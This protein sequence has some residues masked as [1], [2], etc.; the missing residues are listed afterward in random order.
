MRKFIYLF[1]IS[2]ILSSIV[3]A[4]IFTCKDANGNTIYADTPQSCAGNKAEEVKVDSLPT[5]I[6]T[7]SSPTN[8]SSSV[9]AKPE[10]KEKYNSL[11][12][13][14]PNA[15]ETLRSNNGD[16][17]ISYQTDPVLKADVGHRYVVIVNGKEVYR[18]KNSS[19]NLQEADRGEYNV[20]A[21][22]VTANGRT[23]IESQD[24]EFFL[25]RFS[26]LQNGGNNGGGGGRQ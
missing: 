15:G 21:K 17:T 26:A 4:E 16:V 7:K 5:L 11:N 19:V 6:Q 18:G 23:L 25:Q 12:I 10:N 9:E 24:V 1:L 8:S 14:A 20:S 3:H 13:T 22:V 2:A